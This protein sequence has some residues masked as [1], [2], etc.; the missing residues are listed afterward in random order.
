MSTIND[1][2]SNY[3]TRKFIDP[4]AEIRI[5]QLINTIKQRD[6]LPSFETNFEPAEPSDGDSA[7]TTVGLR[8]N[9]EEAFIE[10]ILDL[11]SSITKGGLTTHDILKEILTRIQIKVEDEED[12]NFTNFKLEKESSKYNI[13]IIQSGYDIKLDNNKKIPAGFNGFFLTNKDKEYG[14]YSNNNNNTSNKEIININKYFNSSSK[15]NKKIEDPNLGNPNFSVILYDNITTKFASAQNNELKFFFNGMNN[16][17]LAS[18]YPYVNVIFELPSLQNYGITTKDSTIS[19]NRFL[20]GSNSE[21]K[22]KVYDKFDNVNSY[23]SNNDETSKKTNTLNMSM[24]TSPNTLNNFNEKYL[25]YLENKKDIVNRKNS[26]LDITKPFGTI[27]SIDIQE[28]STTSSPLK[29]FRTA[30][31]KLTIHD[32]SRV[33]DIIH[34]FSPAYYSN[35]TCRVNVEYGWNHLQSDVDSNIKA[36]II[37]SLKVVDNFI[38]KSATTSSNDSGG[39]DVNLELYTHKV[40]EQRILLKTEFAGITNIINGEF[41]KINIAIQNINNI[42]KK[43]DNQI[44]Y[45][46]LT[47]EKIGDVSAYFKNRPTFESSRINEI[48]N[49]LSINTEIINKDTISSKFFG[50]FDFVPKT[51]DNNSEE[52][53]AA[54]ENLNEFEIQNLLFL[55]LLGD[56]NPFKVITE[57]LERI[58]KILQNKNPDVLQQLTCKT[59]DDP[60]FNKDLKNKLKEVLNVE[61]DNNEFITFGKLMTGLIGNYVVPQTG[62]FDEIQIVFNT[63]N[64]KSGLMRNKSISS[65]LIN[66]Q[67]LIDLLNQEIMNSKKNYTFTVESFIKLVIR[68][69]IYVESKQIGYGLS[70]IEN[71]EDKNKSR[72]ERL[73]KIFGKDADESYFKKPSIDFKVQYINPMRKNKFFSKVQKNKRVYKIIFYD[74]VD[75]SLNSILTNFLNVSLQAQSV[76]KIN[77]VIRN[78]IKNKDNTNNDDI[79]ALIQVIGK[80]NIKKIDDNKKLVLSIPELEGIK[81]RIKRKLPAITVGSQNSPVTKAS[82]NTKT[83]GQIGT[84]KMLENDKSYTI[85]GVRFDNELPMP[86]MHADVDIST[87]GC[88]IA[89]VGNMVFVDFLTNTSIDNSYFITGVSHSISQGKF[90]SNIKLSFKD[91]YGSHTNA[92]NNIYRVLKNYKG[93]SKS[94]LP[95][96]LEEEIRN[97]ILTKQ[98][99]SNESEIRK[100]FIDKKGYSISKQDQ[101]LKD[102]K[103]DK[104]SLDPDKLKRFNI[105][106][107]YANKL[108][109]DSSIETN[110]DILTEIYGK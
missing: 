92:I 39:V 18:L 67:D 57:Q 10:N 94:I 82:F 32:R 24:F 62:E 47:E 97:K 70:G 56:N 96:E 55:L 87:I 104:K 33:P 73:Q 13:K 19:T 60:Y 12:K 89:S 106:M 85:S 91:A 17:D 4:S 50:L 84:L 76:V 38:I 21:Q 90:E 22:S 64:D 77:D 107:D 105:K 79:R 7:T 8:G 40:L 88:P 71:K 53:K 9:I 42:N 93:N 43:N 58:K 80:D 81:K 66:K 27:K 95:K 25:G 86:S 102:K 101:V 54:L 109:S 68:R 100:I 75:S 34:F 110:V 78:V 41:K 72:I 98:K 44:R 45:S 16:I 52:K 59:Q 2:L 61:V 5:K 63:V 99:I 20:F 36:Q 6:M 28:K 11:F 30:S 26:V 23:Y 29:P 37:D 1:L 103:V 69:F 46:F 51:K 3:R 35:Q 65:F 108:F 31:M 14:S 48:I 74:K 83:S 15:F 49:I